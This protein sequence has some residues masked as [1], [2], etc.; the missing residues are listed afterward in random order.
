MNMDKIYFKLCKCFKEFKTY[1]KE[2]VNET[3]NTL[4]DK[5][6]KK[7]KLYIAYSEKDEEFYINNTKTI[8]AVNYETIQ[9]RV[10]VSNYINIYTDGKGRLIVDYFEYDF[11]QCGFVILLEDNEEN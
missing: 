3:L 11:W 1:N 6:I 10:K 5:Q 8:K 7:G 2:E 4:L 9:G